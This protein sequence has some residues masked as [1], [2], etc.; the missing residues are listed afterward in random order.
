[1]QKRWR[2]FNY[3]G[4]IAK[5][6]GNLSK[7]CCDKLEGARIINLHK[8]KQYVHELTAHA[9]LCNSQIILSGEQRSGLDS[10]NFSHC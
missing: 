5:R 10:V 3:T 2:A 9:M 6:Q 4:K 7:E 1:M 8:L